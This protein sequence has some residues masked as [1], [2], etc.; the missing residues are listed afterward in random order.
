MIESERGTGGRGGRVTLS[1]PVQGVHEKHWTRRV[2]GHTM[3]YKELSS[4]VVHAALL[5]AAVVV[6]KIE[7][8]QHSTN[9]CLSPFVVRYSKASFAFFSKM[10]TTPNVHH[11]PSR[12][13]FAL[14][15]I[16]PGTYFPSL[17]T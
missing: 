8:G 11:G 5:A 4:V 17:Q 10:G 6:G 14:A 9:A 2:K 15:L 3:M 1:S 12:P 13:H 16:V 7:I